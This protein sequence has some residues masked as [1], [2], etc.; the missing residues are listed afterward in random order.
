MLDVLYE[1]KNNHG[2]RE[3]IAKTNN[4]DTLIECITNLIDVTLEEHDPAEDY[5]LH[6][7]ESYLY[8]KMYELK[9]HDSRLDM[10]KTITQLE[11]ELKQAHKA[12]KVLFDDLT[13]YITEIDRLKKNRQDLIIAYENIIAKEV[14]ENDRQKAKLQAIYNVILE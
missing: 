2:H 10:Q 9:M 1:L 4:V 5:I 13:D 14:K 3:A 7:L 6:D 12:I 8:V 11:N